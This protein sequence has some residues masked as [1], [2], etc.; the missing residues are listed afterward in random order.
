M[1]YQ[2][3]D[4]P[5]I[6]DFKM[7]LLLKRP[8]YETFF[9][10]LNQQKLPFGIVIPILIPT[11]NWFASQIGCKDRFLTTTPLANHFC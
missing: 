6:S 3:A 9:C 1:T 8:F 7:T 11:Q 2:L 10:F 5:L 4:L